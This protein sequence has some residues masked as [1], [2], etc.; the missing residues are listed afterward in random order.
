[1]ADISV[2]IGGVD[3]TAYIERLEFAVD[4]TLGQRATATVSFVDR[5]NALRPVVDDTISII[6]ANGT[7]IVFGGLIAKTAETP[8]GRDTGL[9]RRLECVSAESYA[10][11]RLVTEDFAA[12]L[13]LKQVLSVLVASYLDDY[14]VIL[15]GGQ[16]FGPDL[17]ALS[18]DHRLLTDVLNEL[19]TIT[20]WIWTIKVRAGVVPELLFEEPGSNAAPE[21]I[22][23]ADTNCVTFAYDVAR[24][25]Y[26]NR[27]ILKI[28][29]FAQIAKTDVS[30]ADGAQRVYPL[31]YPIAAAPGTITVT[32]TD[33]AVKPLGAYGVDVMEWTYASS[34]NSLYQ[35]T[36]YAVLSSGTLVSAE[37]T[38]RFPLTIQSD[39][40][41]EQST[42]GIY[43]NLTE[44]P[45]VFDKD[46]GQAI[47]DGLIRRYARKY[48]VVRF[49][50]D[51]PGWEV[52]QTVTVNLTNRAVNTTCLVTSLRTSLLNDETLR[53]EVE[54]VEG[55]EFAGS[56]LDLYRSWSGGAQTLSGSPVVIPAPSLE[57]VAM[58]GTANAFTNYQDITRPADW[59]A[60]RTFVEG[61]TEPRWRISQGGK[62]EWGAGAAS[63]ADVNL[64]RNSTGELKTDDN[65][66][67]AGTLTAGNSAGLGWYDIRAYGASPAASAATNVAS[68]QA[69]IAAAHAAGGPG[70]VVYIPPGVYAITG[71][72]TE[73]FTMGLVTGYPC[74]IVGAGRSSILAPDAATLATTNIIKLV[75]TG[76]TSSQ[77]YRL[78]DFAIVPTGANQGQHGIYIV[79]GEHSISG[80]V[81]ERIF[82]TTNIGGRA[83][84]VDYPDGTNGFFNSIIRDNQLG[85]GIYLNRGGDNLTIER[86][87][88]AGANVG[89]EGMLVDGS[90]LLRILHNTIT[91][92]AGAIAITGAAYQLEIRLNNIEPI[93]PVTGH[94]GAVIDLAGG[95]TDTIINPHILQNSIAAITNDVDNLRLDRVSYAV[96]EGN[97]IPRSGPDSNQI[98]VSSNA[99]DTYIGPNYYTPSTDA[100]SVVLVDSGTRTCFVRVPSGLAALQAPG[101]CVSHS[102]AI[103][104]RW[105]VTS[106]GIQNWSNG[107]TSADVTL[108]RSAADTLKTED[109][110]V[111]SRVVAS[112]PA[113][114]VIGA[115][116]AVPRLY[117]SALGTHYWGEGASGQ[118]TNLYRSA[119][120]TL[121][122]DDALI[123]ADKLTVG[124]TSENYK[125]FSVGGDHVSGGGS[126]TAYSNHFYGSLTGAA[127]DVSQMLGTVLGNTMITQT[128]NSTLA[129]AAQLYVTEPGITK[130][131]DAISVAASVYI[132]GAPTEAVL[133]YALLVASGLTYLGGSVQL[134]AYT[135]SG[136]DLLGDVA[137]GTV[138][139]NSETKKLNIY[140]GDTWE[141]LATS[142]AT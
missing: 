98:V 9:R 34:D 112:D 55:D 17:G 141:Q 101:F 83:I 95:S 43:E 41:S 26:R 87:I 75:G 39:N 37:Y 92:S 137:A 114:S 115:T 19:S 117:V 69:A 32:S 96:I 109:T 107:S 84:Y 78:A 116:D 38:A 16:Q 35:S 97:F 47:A 36:D 67:V 4:Q 81:I 105:H 127:G 121:R 44:C 57:G 82:I 130:N 134:G 140:N 99:V 142:G 12:G 91:N 119:A 138:V 128:E 31:D 64:Y 54:A 45:D 77:P 113:W 76:Y 52:G 122:T 7:T 28:G 86:N 118:D 49:T 20:G 126:N 63:T 132:N 62:Q 50:T 51:T 73:I 89:I 124:T 11:R 15:N 27:Q 6:G 110:L 106:S 8:L 42:A 61:D 71:D 13:N 129:L 65:F 70:G 10:D 33:A 72:G 74:S 102:T 59:T 123:V 94:N 103:V 40:T 88:I 30:T 90:R 21:T 5:A 80:V 104:P 14:G 23:D 60:I 18:Y 108:Y 125:K 46:V 93:V 53:W 79:P 136:R 66:T 139:F 1:M 120:N 29:G 135:S 25:L 56:W 85:N 111:I 131:V 48:I 22:T 133:N 58:L 24:D 100:D 68:I 2:L 3:R